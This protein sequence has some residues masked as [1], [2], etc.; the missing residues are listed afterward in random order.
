MKY[1]LS[2]LII[3]SSIWASAPQKLS[4]HDI[5]LGSANAPNEVIM[6]FAP[7][8]AHCREYEET[9]LPKIKEK[10]LDTGRVRFILR[11]FPAAGAGLRACQLL[12]CRDKTHYTATLALLMKH[13]D[14]WNA[15]ICQF[16]YQKQ[17]PEAKAKCE[18]V[19][20]QVVR[21]AGLS[22][23]DV[24]KA[25]NN[26][27]LEDDIL[28]RRIMINREEKVLEVPTFVINGQKIEEIL[29]PELLEK[30]LQSPKAQ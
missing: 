3:F 23:E 12:R 21:D 7:D 28:E 13:Q 5:V 11:E 17:H 2:L 8:C 6:Y 27:D 20:A 24:R 16:G 9:I 14:L 29:T 1:V 18:T 22:E 30:M 10:F 26:K 4:D 15:D 19:F 25:F